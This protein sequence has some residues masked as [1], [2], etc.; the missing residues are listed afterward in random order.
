MA[1]PLEAPTSAQADDPIAI[2]FRIE[3]TVD[4][5]LQVGRDSEA[6]AKR[7]SHVER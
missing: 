1:R 4:D 6:F 2:L 7:Y 3:I 5:V